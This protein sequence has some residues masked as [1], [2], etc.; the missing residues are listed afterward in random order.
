M[1]LSWTSKT[2]GMLLSGRSAIHYLQS[3]N[4]TLRL[5]G[6]LG[7]LDIALDALGSFDDLPETRIVLDGNTDLESI[8]FSSLDATNDRGRLNASGN[9]GWAPTPSFDIE[10]ALADLDP[11]LASDLVQG[12]ISASGKARGTF[13]ED[14]LT[15][16][17]SV[18]EAG[19]TRQWPTA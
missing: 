10:Y 8:D 7:K 19:W 2:H 4:G 13:G 3:R 6:N 5:R 11:S 18:R 14:T 15:L 17:V 9:A 16:A 1:N 12:Q